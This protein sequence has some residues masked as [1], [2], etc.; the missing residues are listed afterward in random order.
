MDLLEQDAMPL[1]S[2]PLRARRVI[3][4][5][6]SVTVIYHSTN[7]RVRTRTKA[8]DGLLAYVTFGSRATGMVE[9]LQVRPGMMVVAE[10][11]TEAG[12]V[13][14]PGYES[15]TLLVP[16]EG[17]REHLSARQREGDLR[18]PRRVEVLRADPA[19]ARA[20]FRLGKRLATSASRNPVLFDEGRAER[21]GAQ[22]D[23]LEALLTAMRSTDTLRYGKN[24][25]GT[26]PDRHD[27]GELRALAC[28]GARACVRLVPCRGRERTH[29]RVRLQ[30]HHW[31]VA[32]GIPGTTA[33]AP[34]ARGAPGRGAGIDTSLS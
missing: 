2:R 4:R 10:P 26:Q 3:V 8:H 21:D 14:D 22:V 13:V 33:T 1:Q 20:L 27:R 29:A 16:P 32:D 6:K 7:L 11:K 31:T 19:L 5:L 30:G 9:G 18:W 12:F 15:I 34:S 23:L 24:T 28:R 25:T 17:I